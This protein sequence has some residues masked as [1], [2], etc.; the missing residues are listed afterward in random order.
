MKAFAI[1]NPKGELMHETI[2]P[3]HN[4]CVSNFVGKGDWDKLKEAGF[5]CVE[6]KII[7]QQ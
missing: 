7:E 5:R 2:Q 1:K 3:W 6:I 4:W